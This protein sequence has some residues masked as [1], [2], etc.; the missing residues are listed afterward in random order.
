MELKRWLCPDG[1]TRQYRDGDQ[2]E[3]CTP[4]DEPKK[5]PKRTTRKAGAKDEG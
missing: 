2:P 1:L 4:A 3:G 5:A